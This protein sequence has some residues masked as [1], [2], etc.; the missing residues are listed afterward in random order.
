[1]RPGALVA[2]GALVASTVAAFFVT[3]H[4]KVSSPLLQ[5]F[6]S[7]TP[8]T[9]N[10]YGATCQNGQQHSRM[11]ISFYLQ[12]RADDV[13]VYVVDQSGTIVRT[14]A[15]GR[16]MRRNVRIPDGEFTWNG[17]ED[18]GTVAPDGTYY[19][20]VALLGQGRTIQINKPITIKTAA[21][22]PSVRS[23]SPSLI[24]R[25]GSP[26]RIRY[27]GN[28]N[29]DP[30]ITIYRT[31]LP[32]RPRLV[33][34]FG[35]S[36][37]AP[38]T[39]DGTIAGQP[40]PAGTYLIG[41]QVTDAACNV[42]R[43]PVVLPPPPGTTP[44]AGV[45]VRYIAALPPMDPV[46]AGTHA[47]TFVD[48]RGH[49]FHWVLWRAGARKPITSGGDNPGSYE[50]HVRPPLDNGPG[51]YELSVNAG[52]HLTRVPLV[53]NAANGS[54]KILIVLPALAWQGQNPVDDSP[55]DGLP[56][57]LDSGGPIV[58]KRVL[59]NG[60]P[61]D[62]G[63]IS[64]LLTYL[65]R[66][67]LGYDL[68]TDIGLID[69]TGPTLSGHAGVV[70][71]GSERWLPSSLMDGLKT[72]VQNGGHLLS[73]GTGSLQRRV[74][75]RSGRALGPSSPSATDVFGARPAALVNDNHD[76][77]TVIRDGLGIF[78]GTSQAFSGYRAFQPIAPPES[79]K[80]L[81]E[82]GTATTPQPAIAGFGVGK[83]FVVDM[84]LGGFAQSLQ[85]NVDGQD[86]MRRL[87]TVLAR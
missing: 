70:L 64:A 44:H 7:P 49:G 58:L 42:G 60:L 10:P 53:V 71:A 28:E 40:A 66:N 39:W 82:A 59:A 18:N 86:L 20:R 45:T 22:H 76:L 37:K 74:T 26:V 31:D 67:H 69:G 17:R 13:D 84:A 23:V 77:I 36:H 51:L 33:D 12:H 38:A 30:V 24:P 2:F 52:P 81:S 9:I 79:A 11:Y 55:Q 57:T 80:L 34:E 1:V 35:V 85:H 27:S 32:G 65:D 29:R 14:L 15:I 16:H 50:I 63:D 75:I 56:N 78:S 87:W 19:L 72:Y 25:G 6:P 73:L 61:A 47:T 5:G 46:A 41:L 48:A 62:W 3:Q 8:A 68:T 54:R 21:P 43:F 83:G 4:L